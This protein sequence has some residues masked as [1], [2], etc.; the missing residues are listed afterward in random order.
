MTLQKWLSI[1]ICNSHWPLNRWRWSSSLY[2]GQ[3][4]VKKA[5]LVSAVPPLKLKIIL[6]VYQKK[7][8]T[9]CNSHQPCAIFP[10]LTIWPVLYRPDA[11]PSE[12]II[13]NWW[14]Q[15]AVQKHI[16]MVLWHS[17]KLTRFKENHHSCFGI[18]WWR[19]L[20]YKTSG[21]KSAELL[22]NSQSTQVFLT[23]C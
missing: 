1:W 10:R 21:V 16:T 11:K 20:P 23:V 6:K 15:Q 5:V 9:I 12:G 19:R 17:H 13:A 7:F 3:E 2:Y 4:N 14:R 8:L 18:T 22:Q